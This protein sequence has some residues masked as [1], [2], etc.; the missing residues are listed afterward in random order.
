MVKIMHVQLDDSSIIGL[1]RP[2]AYC[3][4]NIRELNFT[5]SFKRASELGYAALSQTLLN[6]DALQRVFIDGF[7]SSL[8]DGMA[9]ACGSKFGENALELLPRVSAALHFE[10]LPSGGM[11]NLPVATDAKAAAA[12]VLISCAASLVGMYCNISLLPTSSRGFAWLL[13]ANA[14]RPNNVT[15][16]LKS[17][18]TSD[19]TLQSSQRW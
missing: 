18:R 10:T 2:L 8:L 13:Q 19:E 11:I 9:I 1:L 6:N 3:S 7:C 5:G 14:Q 16:Y 17:V 15:L 12:A 4:R